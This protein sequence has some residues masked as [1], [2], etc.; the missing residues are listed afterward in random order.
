MLLLFLKGDL[1]VEFADSF[2]NTLGFF[3]RTHMGAAIPKYF[4][5]V[6]NSTCI[7][8][9]GSRPNIC[10]YSCVYYIHK[11]PYTTGQCKIG[12]YNQATMSP[13]IV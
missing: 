11:T 9:E 1:K 13:F 3:S 7:H 2:Q 12:I 6:M 8:Y 10:M 4:V 5:T